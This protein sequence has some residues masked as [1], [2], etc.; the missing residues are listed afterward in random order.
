MRAVFEKPREWQKIHDR[1]KIIEVIRDRVR[2]R[3]FRM[4]WTNPPAEFNPAEIRDEML[5]FYYPPNLE[6]QSPI[7]LYTTLGRQL[8]IDFKIVEVPEPGTLLL[9]PLEARV[10]RIKRM[11]DRILTRSENVFATN[12]QVSKRES[13]L[14]G[15]SAV[16]SRI[17]FAE[18][19]R[20]FA[21]KYPGIRIF[22]ASTRDLPA[23][24]KV[25][26]KC[27]KPVFEDSLPEPEKRERFADLKGELIDEGIYEAEQRR[28]RN[29]GIRS[30]VAYPMLFDSGD[31]MTSVIGCIRLEKKGP[32]VIDNSLFESLE[33]DAHLIIQRVIE[34]NTFHVSERQRVLNFSE[35]GA[36]IEITNEDLM[37]YIP[38]K[39]RLTFDL[40]FRKQAPVRLQAR[41]CHVH[42]L[43]NHRMVMGIVF[44]GTGW[45]GQ[46][47]NPLLRLKELVRLARMNKI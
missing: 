33:S 29:H 5:L 35:E 42:R 27:K 11:L 23:D 25:A 19:E 24:V 16:A 21:D 45:Y 37:S 3:P 36:A 30:L 34:A 10:G 20:I 41:I 47:T 46:K 7:T 2:M 43:L 15:A 1:Q 26:A 9:L 14:S 32:D 18:F 44:D 22:D 31:G 28:W 40:V 17:I 6:I 13:D 39:N 4:K 38:E 12:F 8:E